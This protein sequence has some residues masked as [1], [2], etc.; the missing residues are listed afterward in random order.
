MALW[1]L[2]NIR[3]NRIDLLLNKL[4]SCD[5]TSDDVQ[6]FVKVCWFHL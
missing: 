4:K 3:Y 2:N 6:F 1:Q 5:P